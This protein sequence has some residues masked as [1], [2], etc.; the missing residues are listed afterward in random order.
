MI[1][2]VQASAIIK[3]VTELIKSFKLWVYNED[4]QRGLMRHIL[5]RKGMS[6]KQIMVVLV[7]ASPE[8]PHKNNFVEKITGNSSGNHNNCPECEY[9]TDNN[10]VRREEPPSVWAGVYRG[11][12]LWA[13]IS[14]LT[15]LFLSGKF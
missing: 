5:I 11:C 13:A 1:E 2:D 4:T 3:T 12:T 15:R 14:N 8:F 6:T 9:E 7:T 10:G